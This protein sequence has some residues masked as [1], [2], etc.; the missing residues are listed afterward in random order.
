MK[1][2][3]IIR[4]TLK[5]MLS[6]IL[7]SI[8]AFSLLASLLFFV[9]T[10]GALSDLIPIGKVV[11]SEKLNWDKITSIGG[12]GLIIDVDGKMVKAYNYPG[13]KAVYTSDEI[14]N[15][16]SDNKGIFNFT[17]MLQ[18]SK[19]T[20]IFNE[21]NGNRLL[22]MYPKNLISQTFNL[23]I[24]ELMGSNSYLFLLLLLGIFIVYLG[25]LFII[26]KR[27][28]KSL[29]KELEEL[30]AQEEERKDLLFKGLAHDIKT[31]LSGILAF[32]KA[33][34]D[35]IVDDTQIKNY[36]RGIYK[37]GQILNDR[38][39]DMLELS[40]LNEEGMYNPKTSDI[41][42]Y[43][44]RYI[45][46]NYIWFTENDADISLEID[47]DEKYITEFDQ[48][49]FERV[50]QN[51]LQN[52]VYHNEGHVKISIRFD[53]KNKKLIF[54]DDGKGIHGKL[55]ENIFNPMVTG[56]ESRSGEKL[57]G[58]GL[59]NVKRIVDLH[60][61]NIYYEEGFIIKM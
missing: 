48:K 52:S 14:L 51:I 39:N 1:T 60:K 19:T 41:L 56:D 38:I 8:I 40:V 28:S 23:N 33:L 36:Y 22:L 58:M 3:R 57:R 54:K 34:S 20:F 18:K 26:I 31:P 42:E 46:D 47:E 13:A 4:N 27:L 17:D 53:R 16:L 5:F 37:N 29:N 15:M 59:A 30:K 50:L 55:I 2:N 9:P 10:S 11:D 44:R 24:N 45:G 12:A 21:E 49:L 6:F 7:I 43:I 32:T 61:W 35:G 25:L